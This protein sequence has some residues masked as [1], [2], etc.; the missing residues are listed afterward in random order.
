MTKVYIP[1]KNRLINKLFNPIEAEKDISKVNKSFIEELLKYTLNSVPK[2]EVVF[3]DYEGQYIVIETENSKDYIMFPYEISHSKNAS[4]N[5]YLLTKMSLPFHDFCFD[6]TSKTKNFSIFL[7]DMP[8]ETYE[9]YNNSKKAY[10][11]N[12]IDIDSLQSESLINDYQLFVYRLAKT[13]NINILNED[14]LPFS[15]YKNVSTKDNKF[16]YRGKE[17][18]IK[19]P[20]KSTSEIKKQ[21]R[22]LSKKNSGNRSSYILESKDSI[23]IYAKTYGNNGYE[24]TMIACAIAELAKKEGKKVILYQLKD[25][26][27]VDGT[28]NKKAQT[29]T[30]KNKEL[31]TYFGVE[32]LDDIQEYEDNPE[33]NFDDRKDSRNQAEFRKNLMIK[34]GEVGEEDTKKCALCECD[35]QEL[36]IAAHIHRVCDINKLKIPFAE[37]VKKTTDGNN[38]LWL[39]R[40][41]DKLFEDGII[42]FNEDT[43][44]LEINEDDLTESQI[45]YIKNI[46]TKYKIDEKHMNDETKS[47]LKEHNARIKNEKNKN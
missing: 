25:N 27:G 11:A 18:V 5:G 44:K 30:S 4:R 20:F 10:S 28:E 35:I 24:I 36:I 46:T 12:D 32:V 8:L 34:W 47:Y 41:H 33:I 17:L 9:K 14:K 40:N 19:K 42:T 43:G 16:P 31:L 7:L 38:G 23:F 13:L 29:L 39:C 1:N 37:K 3:E 21:R 2:Y 6:K 26:L 22:L 45:S 15:K